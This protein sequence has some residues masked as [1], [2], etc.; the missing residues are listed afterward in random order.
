L[1]RKTILAIAMYIFFRGRFYKIYSHRTKIVLAIA[2]YSTL[3]AALFIG[4]GVSH[5]TSH[6]D[7]V[8]YRFEAIL[9]D[10]VIT[11]NITNLPIVVVEGYRSAAG[12]KSVN[13]TI[14]GVLYAYPKDFSYNETFRVEAN[15]AT[16]KS[17]V[18]V[19]TTL[20][21]NLPGYSTITEYMTS[22]VT[23]NGTSTVT[24]EGVFYLMGAGDFSSI[25][26]GG[27]VESYG[28]GGVDYAQHIGLIK[29]WP[30]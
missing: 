30:V 4:V 29:E 5:Y 2:L 1:N 19:T 23:R 12:V 21:F 11:S 9:S 24:D 3:V 6:V 16:G 18:T 8:P 20:T 26:G 17:I 25:S 14:N 28:V 7:Y 22:Q 15:I 27:F 13:L 10:P